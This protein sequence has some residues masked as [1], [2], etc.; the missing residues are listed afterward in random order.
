MALPPRPSPAWLGREQPR[1]TRGTF[2]SA[3]A[4]VPHWARPSRGRRPG[5]SLRTWL[6]RPPPA[7]R[8]SSLLAF[9]AAGQ[10][11]GVPVL[12]VLRETSR[13]RGAVMPSNEPSAFRSWPAREERSPLARPGSKWGVHVG[14]PEKIERA[15]HY[16]PPKP[17]CPASE[18]EKDSGFSD[19]SS[20]SLSAIEQTDTED[21]A[22][23]CLPPGPAELRKAKGGLLASTFP[24]LLA[25]LYLIKNMIPK[26]TLGVSPTAPFLAWSNQHPLDNH[27]CS[28]AR[29][30]LLQEPMAFLKPTLPS[31]K[32]SAKE[33]HFPTLGT[34]P[35]IA[36]HPGRQAEEGPSP[37][38][39]P[40]RHKQF[41][42]AE[43]P[44]DT[45]EEP[46]EESPGS[47]QT[48]ALG[49][50][51]VPARPPL[52]SCPGL[53]S[54]G[55]RAVIKGA[56]RLGGQSLA[57]QRR[58]RNTVEIL[59]RSGLLAITL[60][61]KELLRQN[62]ST[63][64]ELAQLREQAQLLCEAIRSSDSRA[65]ARLQDAVGRSAAP[66][67]RKGGGTLTHLGE[68]PNLAAQ[69]TGPLLP[70]PGE[71]LSRSGPALG[72]DTPLAPALP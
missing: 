12:C 38:G 9:A 53:A 43:A 63:Q 68:Q 33:I 20:E 31:Q 28:A 47:P 23:P 3:P 21:Q 36:C 50:P 51:E 61:T 8:G 25:P 11:G 67:P 40:G 39:E 48:S 5:A 59:R 1:P 13:T 14:Q 46:P 24:A 6:P 42:V 72:P 49:S 60:R 10:L 18:G 7:G 57:R 17:S 27:H 62:S 58:L 69:P 65:W 26:Q 29:L 16:G 64:R 2:G 66:W 15:T 44:K 56:R 4:R 32:P 52:P 70:S 37:A 41:C 22:A 34:Y 45:C 19:G 30:L 54:A 71:L 35:R 55:G